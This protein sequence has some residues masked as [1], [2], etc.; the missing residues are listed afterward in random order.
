MQSGIPCGCKR[1]VLSE[2]HLKFRMTN[3]SVICRKR[4]SF[5]S[6]FG[7]LSLSGRSRKQERCQKE[8]LYPLVESELCPC[9]EFVSRPY[10]NWSSCILSETPAQGSLQGWRGRREA[11]DCGQGLRFRAVA[12]LDQQNQLVNPDF[13]SETGSCARSSFLSRSFSVK[14][15]SNPSSAGKASGH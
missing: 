6:L 13:C 9:D 15:L 3:V 8:D 4:F 14:G 2:W 1:A 5:P 10:G 7:F 12:C 11:R